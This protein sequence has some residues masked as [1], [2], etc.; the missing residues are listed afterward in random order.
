MK[1]NELLEEDLRTLKETDFMGPTT[2]AEYNRRKMLAA[3]GADGKDRNLRKEAKVKYN[4]EKFD[5]ILKQKKSDQLKIARQMF[6][7]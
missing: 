1:L 6:G 5:D 4:F 7:N 2:R 3:G